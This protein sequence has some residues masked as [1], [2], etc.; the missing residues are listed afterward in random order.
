MSILTILK[1]HDRKVLE[2]NLKEENFPQKFLQGK[3]QDPS[4]YLTDEGAG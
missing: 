1:Q 2:K 4:P 3:L